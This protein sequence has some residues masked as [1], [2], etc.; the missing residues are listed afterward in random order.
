VRSAN[1]ASGRATRWR[2]D[3]PWAPGRRPRPRPPCRRRA[4][5]MQR[6]PD[7]PVSNRHQP[8]PTSQPPP[9]TYR[10][11]SRPAL[12]FWFRPLKFRLPAPPQIFPIL[13]SK[14]TDLSPS[15]SRERLPVGKCFRELPVDPVGSVEPKTRR[16]AVR[17][18][19]APARRTRRDSIWPRDRPVAYSNRGRDTWAGHRGIIGDLGAVVRVEAAGD[20]PPSATPSVSAPARACRD[21]LTRLGLGGRPG[22]RPHVRTSAWAV[23]FNVHHEVGHSPNDTASGALETE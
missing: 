23:G 13:T 18:A 21:L 12:G 1:G 6:G 3:Q 11:R 22:A 2:P 14:T 7:R 5:T 8:S 19:S 4:V 17:H 15:F 16:L 9:R 20:D 10:P